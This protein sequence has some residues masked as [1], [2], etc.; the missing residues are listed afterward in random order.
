MISY[1]I[2]LLKAKF[3]IYSV[4]DAREEYYPDLFLVYSL[5]AFSF[6]CTSQHFD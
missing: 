1:H 6:L 5:L 4:Q 2:F 3:V